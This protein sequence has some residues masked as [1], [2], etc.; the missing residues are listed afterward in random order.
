MS[1]P[2]YDAQDMHRYY[3]MKEFREMRK[4]RDEMDRAYTYMAERCA[5]LAIQ[6]DE[7][8]AALMEIVATHEAYDAMT[9]QGHEDCIYI[10]KDAIAKAESDV[11][12]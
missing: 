10:A 11:S 7:L 3:D 8:L 1:E 5:T 12:H 4:Q 6:R 9:G 2:Q